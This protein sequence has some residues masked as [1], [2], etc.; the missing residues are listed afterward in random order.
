MTDFKDKDQ[1]DQ[2][3]SFKEQILAW[4]PLVPNDLETLESQLIQLLVC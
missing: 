3:R 2:Q 4:N 1:Q